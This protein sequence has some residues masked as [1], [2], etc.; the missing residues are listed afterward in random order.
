MNNAIRNSNH[1]LIDTTG[2]GGNDDTIV[3]GFDPIV[4]EQMADTGDLHDQTQFERK[5]KKTK[6]N[7]RLVVRGVDGEWCLKRSRR[8]VDLG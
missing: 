2:G 4:V 6:E 7:R 5:W 3:M 8:I 1:R